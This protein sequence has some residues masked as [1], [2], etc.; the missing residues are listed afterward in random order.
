MKVCDY[1]VLRSSSFKEQ[2]DYLCVSE[3]LT[4]STASSWL[5]VYLNLQSA[6]AHRVL[7]YMIIGIG[8]WATEIL[9]PRISFIE[10]FK[11]WFLAN[12]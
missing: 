3:F 6:R 9:T 12:V 4:T 1:E 8:Q 11:L 5:F 10:H 2:G 7:I